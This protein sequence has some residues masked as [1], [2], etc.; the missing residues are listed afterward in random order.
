MKNN[1][2]IEDVCYNEIITG[3]RL[4]V[5]LKIKY[6]YENMKVSKE[7]IDKRINELVSKLFEYF[8]SSNSINEK[9]NI[10]RSINNI[11]DNIYN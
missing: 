8:I 10:V 9:R 11:Y 3:H 5:G 1:I 4:Y 6:D 2:T 7:E